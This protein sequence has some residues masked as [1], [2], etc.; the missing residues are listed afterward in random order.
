MPL[1]RATTLAHRIL[2]DQIPAG[3]CVVDATVGN[4]HDTEF[5]AALVGDSGRVHGFDVQLA[6]LHSAKERLR[7]AGL[8]HRVRWHHEGHESLADHVDDP[9]RAVMFNLGYLPGGDHGLTTTAATTLEACSSAAAL[10]VEGGVLS[11]VLYRGHPGGDM[12]AQAVES[13]I[14]GL[15]AS[16]WSVARYSP[17]GRRREAPSLLL[18]SKE[19]RLA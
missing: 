7:A 18:A 4:G 15:D 9:L 17:L 16:H 13:W 19:P 5:L 6:A 10:L 14:L 1:P 3:S 2:A 8:D 11:L 12:E